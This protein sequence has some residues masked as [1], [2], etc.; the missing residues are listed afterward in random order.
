[1][2]ICAQDVGDF[3]EKIRGTKMMINMT[4][5]EFWEGV[6]NRNKRRL[7]MILVDYR[8]LLDWKKVVKT[9]NW[10]ARLESNDETIPENW[11]KE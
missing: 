6:F 7:G 1:M 8:Y 5:D 9:K 3:R 4:D 2:E 10:Q 11:Y